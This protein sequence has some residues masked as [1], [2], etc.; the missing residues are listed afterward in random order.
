MAYKSKAAWE[1]AIARFKKRGMSLEDIR[2][3]LVFLKRV[4]KNL[5]FI[6]EVTSK[7]TKL[8]T[9]IKEIGAIKNVQQIYNLLKKVRLK[10]L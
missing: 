2:K 1:A 8:L 6:V 10:N 9:E 3:E 5:Q 7:V 4:I